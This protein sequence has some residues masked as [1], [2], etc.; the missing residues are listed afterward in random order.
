[1]ESQID[2]AGRARHLWKH[3][4][5]FRSTQPSHQL[6]C[7]ATWKRPNSG[8][9]SPNRSSSSRES[10]PESNLKA[11]GMHLWHPSQSEQRYC[12]TPKGTPQANEICFHSLEVQA[13]D[14]FDKTLNPFTD[15]AGHWTQAIHRVSW[16]WCQAETACLSCTNTRDL[17]GLRQGR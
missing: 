17:N 16:Q 3:S 11:Q 12:P 6:P 5:A 9:P 7:F 15:N 4:S 8:K 13:G 14:S 10:V 1:M 2:D